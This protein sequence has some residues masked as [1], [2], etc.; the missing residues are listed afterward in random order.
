VTRNGRVDL[1]RDFLANVQPPTLLLVGA[2]D[3]PIVRINETA[4]LRLGAARKELIMIPGSSRRFEDSAE[5][6]TA[7]EL[8]AD[9][10]T[11]YLILLS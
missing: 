9:W 5:L 8:A 11:R 2:N 1:A 6:A 4:L 3:A 7:A 10:F